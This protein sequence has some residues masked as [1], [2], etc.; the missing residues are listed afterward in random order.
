MPLLAPSIWRLG[1]RV[2]P[3][4]KFEGGR[5]KIV[6]RESVRDLLPDDVVDA[7]KHGLFDVAVED[8]MARRY[9]HRVVELFDHSR[10]AR[11][12]LL[13]V[14]AFVEA[15]GRYCRGVGSGDGPL[16]GSLALWRTIAAELWVR[17]VTG[18]T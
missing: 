5:Q 14:E 15:F 13:D 9:R 4:V 10:L 3:S 18:E 6:L 8:A 11:L 1:L 12:G 7:P 17:E 16:Y 2:P